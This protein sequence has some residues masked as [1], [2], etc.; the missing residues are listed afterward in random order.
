MPATILHPEDTAV[1][2]TGWGLVFTSGKT[3]I[4]KLINKPDH[5]R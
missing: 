1:E 5:F 2:Q 4:K 3:E